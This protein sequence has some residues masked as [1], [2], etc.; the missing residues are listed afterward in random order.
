[1]TFSLTK[2]ETEGAW[3]AEHVSIME[4]ALQIFVLDQRFSFVARLLIF[5]NQYLYFPPD[6]IV[7]KSY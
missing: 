2:G 7:K 3:M 5:P 4:D 1:M 6:T